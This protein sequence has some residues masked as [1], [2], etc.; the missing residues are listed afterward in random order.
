MFVYVCVCVCVCVRVCASGSSVVRFAG[1]NLGS[2]PQSLYYY[3]SY[4]FHGTAQRNRRYALLTTANKPQT[5]LYRAPTFCLLQASHGG[6]CVCVCVYVCT[7]MCAYACVC[8]CVCGGCSVGVLGEDVCERVERGRGAGP[9]PSILP[10]SSL[11]PQFQCD[12]P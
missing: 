10:D 11:A 4:I 3:Q 12:V 9:L 1:M 8:T 7:Y 6:L 2:E 5:V